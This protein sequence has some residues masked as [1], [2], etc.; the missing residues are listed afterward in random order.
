M[1]RLTARL[2]LAGLLAVALP[3]QG[4]ATERGRQAFIQ[5][6]CYGCHTIGAVGTPIG[7]DLSRIGRR[8]SASDL[9]RWLRD[10]ESVRPKAHMP[11][12]ELTEEEIAALAEFLGSL[13]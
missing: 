1:A 6:G 8:Y 7:P 10:P 4:A 5:Q 12:L 11:V 2:V 3:A 9:R 13:R